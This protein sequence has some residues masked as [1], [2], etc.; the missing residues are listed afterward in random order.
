MSFSF[1]YSG[2]H[3]KEP[4]LERLLPLASGAGWQGWEI[5]QSLDW[6]GS[7]RRVRGLCRDAD[8]DVAAVCGPNA[9]LSTADPVHQIGKRRI[10]FAA[11]LEVTTFMTKGPGRGQL[12]PEGESAASDELLDRMAAVYEDLAAY[13]APLGVTVT[14]H[15]H[16]RHL[17]DS[18]D[19]WKRFMVRL[20]QCRLCM[21]M[22]HAVF[23]DYD[24]VV[25][26]GDFAERISYVHLHDDRDGAGVDL[27][28][29]PMCDYAA[30]LA[31]L[32]EIGYG[33]WITVCPGSADRP[34]E[35]RLRI[36]REYLTGLGY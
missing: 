14:F 1:A 6:L 34:E 25:A 17:V 18:A 13:A 23:W 30:F 15:P 16:V 29:G 12:V 5:R 9:T 3:W 35:E 20:D 24:P 36:N 21:D 26:V 10:E 7:P 11:E 31:R 22:S 27:G 33:G 32:E 28:E 19:E 2:L 8:I 4:R